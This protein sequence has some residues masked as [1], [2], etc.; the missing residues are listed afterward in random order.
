MEYDYGALNHERQSGST[1]WMVE[2]LADAILEGQPHAVVVG[3]TNQ[4]VRDH[5]FPMVFRALIDRGIYP[6][7]I[8]RANLHMEAGGSV[9]NFVSINTPKFEEMI[10]TINPFFFF[11]D[12]YAWD[13]MTEHQRRLVFSRPCQPSRYT[14][15]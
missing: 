7:T 2:T 8:N 14:D 5:L 3:N 13:C 12:H 1:T 9:I 6:D 10:Q 4:F 11:I 15:D